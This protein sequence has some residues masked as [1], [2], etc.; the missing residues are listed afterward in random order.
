MP[1]NK[2]LPET[3]VGPDVAADAEPT[4]TFAYQGEPGAYSELAALRH[5]VEEPAWETD[6]RLAK[7]LPCRA[8]ADVVTAVSDSEADFGIL[9]VEN[10]TEG[11]ID[12]STDLFRDLDLHVVGE[13]EL[14]IRHC[15]LAVEGTTIP[16][17]THVHSHP[18]GL[19]QC[20]TYLDAFPQ[21]K[22]V[23]EEDTAGAAAHIAS[24]QLVGHAAIASAH[25]AKTYGL[26]V[27][28]EGIETRHENYTRFLV[29]ARDPIDP[30]PD[31][32][33]IEKRGSAH[34]K[35]SLLFAVRGRPGTLHEA[36]GVFADHDV[37]LTKLESRPWHR[38]G[39]RWD[40]L[41]LVDCQG[42]SAEPHVAQAFGVLAQKLHFLKVLGSYP[43]S[44]HR[45]H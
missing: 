45:D 13:T 23:A 33:R 12:E 16:D 41:F 25:A 8:F 22:R 6:P 3:P 35:T 39:R 19:R 26:H 43:E 42:H 15:L 31:Q 27:V 11:N 44:L 1:S 24:E 17:I 20:R 5:L 10:S 9:P 7:G 2:L 30:E 14:R 34:Y 18:Q 37:N 28:E 29:I 38:T 21:W 4:L 36:L 40:Y 32:T